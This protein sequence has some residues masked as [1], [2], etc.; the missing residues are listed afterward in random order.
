MA[1][2]VNFHQSLSHEAKLEKPVDYVYLCVSR[3]IM[4]ARY[5]ILVIRRAIYKQRSTTEI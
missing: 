5:Y 4:T 2:I 3:A 1:K